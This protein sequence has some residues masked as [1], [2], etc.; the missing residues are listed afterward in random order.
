[1]LGYALYRLGRN[2]E[3][4]EVLDMA[5]V[6]AGEDAARRGQILGDRA[7][8]LGALGHHDEA[9]AG[10]GQALELAPDSA[11]LHHVLGFVLHFAGR[12]ADAIGPIQRALEIDPSFAAA[13]KTLALAQAAAR[14]RRG[15]RRG[16]CSRRCAT[17]PL[18]R[19]AV[20][21]LSLL[22]IE[23]KQ[24]AEALEAL[25]PYLREAPDDVRALNNQ[26]LAL[27][28]LKRFDEARRALKRA[29][30]L[31]ADD[32]LVL[33]NLGR[34]LVDLGRAGEARPL[35]EHALRDPA[36]R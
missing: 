10:A 7:L 16:C 27:R 9:I 25:E 36:G 18:D 11:C 30:R 22:H 31:S 5:L 19:D 14:Q 6:D 13:L 15:R 34:V 20:L 35:H 12:P 33:T 1:M 21:Q 28:G 32:P 2:A 3:A 24:F 23:H 4:I 17:N 26:G 8:A 29:S